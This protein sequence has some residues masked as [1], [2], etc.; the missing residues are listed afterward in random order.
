M[1]SKCFYSKKIHKNRKN[2]LQI[3]IFVS[4]IFF[5]K[6]KIG[7]SIDNSGPK[8]SKFQ[9][10]VILHQ[11][12]LKSPESLKLS[13]FLMS[14]FKGFKWFSEK[15]SREQKTLFYHS[16]SIFYFFLALWTSKRHKKFER[17]IT[18]FFSSKRD[19]CEKYWI[20]C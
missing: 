5:K 15:Y 10:M 13:K 16:L 14:I 9:K 1:L 6:I 7:S 12:W 18:I 8:F 3:E 20:C 17:N 11:K 19:S 4:K 2:T